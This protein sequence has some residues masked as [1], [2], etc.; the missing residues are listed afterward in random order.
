[1]FL[2]LIVPWKQAK[3]R[4]SCILDEG[5]YGHH[6]CC[7]ACHLMCD[8]SYGIFRPWYKWH[9]QNHTLVRHRRNPFRNTKLDT[10]TNKANTITKDRR[11]TLHPKAFSIVLLIFISVV[12]KVNKSLDHYNSPTYIMPFDL[13][14]ILCVSSADDNILWERM[15]C[16]HCCKHP[17]RQE[18]RHSLHNTISHLCQCKITCLQLK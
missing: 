5:V 10:L 9:Q 16:K 6:R 2:H 7:E 1:M 18:D 3:A 11:P 13:I 17:Y 8:R 4:Y 15:H 12:I 14:Y